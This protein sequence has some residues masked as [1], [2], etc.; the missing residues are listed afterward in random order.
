FFVSSR[1][2]QLAPARTAPRGVLCRLAEAGPPAALRGPIPRGPTEIGGRRAMELPC[3]PW[4]PPMRF[5]V[6]PPPGLEDVRSEVGGAAAGMIDF[7]QMVQYA[8]QSP[9]QAVPAAPPTTSAGFLWDHMQNEELAQ[10]EQLQHVLL[11]EHLMQQ[12]ACG[13]SGEWVEAVLSAAPFLDAGGM[14]AALAILDKAHENIQRAKPLD[15]IIAS[16]H[17]AG[18]I[19]T[20]M[21]HLH[22]VEQMKAQLLE[23]QQALLRQLHQLRAFSVTGGSGAAAR[24]AQRPGALRLG[25]PAGSEGGAPPRPRQQQ[26]HQLGPRA[27]AKQEE[28]LLA[29]PPWQQPRPRGPQARLS[30]VPP[31]VPQQGAH[32]PAQTLSSSL[33]LLAAEDPDCLFVVRRINRLGFQAP[34]RL[35]RHFSGCGPVSQVLLAHSTLHE[36]GE[37]RR[38]ARAAAP[39]AWAS[40]TW[41]R[42]RVLAALSPWEE[43]RWW[44][45]ASSSCSASSVSRRTTARRTRTTTKSRTRSTIRAPRRELLAWKGA[46]LRG[47]SASPRS[48]SVRARTTAGRASRA[49]SPP[50]PPRAGPQRGP[51]LGLP[52]RM[53]PPAQVA[54]L[55]RKP[56]AERARSEREGGRAPPQAGPGQGEARPMKLLCD[57]PI[58]GPFR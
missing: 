36:S 25:P 55:A 18:G 47:T 53:A 3:T 56:R 21:P 22:A 30:A 35:K 49:P 5:A 6:P 44:T 46:G 42:P 52:P 31:E 33:Q 43:S 23:E 4:E 28:Q 58:S 9:E 57:P 50:D 12:Q 45:A 27:H 2:G 41:P 26:G 32:G 10:A 13:S 38:C 15:G 8:T 34:R 51:G 39:A 16:T 29:R 11:Q 20:S 54:P 24:A 37:S 17:A 14:K 40:C 7:A 1:V 48:P 19:F